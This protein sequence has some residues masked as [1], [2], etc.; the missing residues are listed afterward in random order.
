MKYL[1]FNPSHQNRESLTQTCLGLSG[2]WVYW[3]ITF[4]K[5]HLNMHCF[6]YSWHNTFTLQVFNLIRASYNSS[7]NHYKKTLK[8]SSKN[9]RTQWYVWSCTVPFKRSQAVANCLAGK[10]CALVKCTFSIGA[11]YTTVI[12]CPHR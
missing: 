1:N 2:L 6:T 4:N 11:E 12:G 5:Q 9:E 7:A 3:K 8:M 10:K